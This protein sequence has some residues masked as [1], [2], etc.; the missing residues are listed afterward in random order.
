M[1]LVWNCFH[2]FFVLCARHLC[3]SHPVLQTLQTCPAPSLSLSLARP[4]PLTQVRKDL[5]KTLETLKTVVRRAPKRQV[6]VESMPLPSQKP[7]GY[8]PPT[9]SDDASPRPA[10]PASPDPAQDC[11]A[12]GAVS[13]TDTSAPVVGSQEETVAPFSSVLQESRDKHAG[14]SN[15]YSYQARTTVEELSETAEASLHTPSPT[16]AA[17]TTA[18]ASG[19]AL[20]T[21]SNSAPPQEGRASTETASAA[22]GM[23]GEAAAAA[24]AA[25]S[26]PKT[27]NSD[28]ARPAAS[29][30]APAGDDA[31]PSP[32]AAVVAAAEAG[33]GRPAVSPAAESDR[34][35]VDVKRASNKGSASGDETGS[36]SREARGETA[37]SPPLNGTAEAK[38]TAAQVRPPPPP[39][40]PS[41][42]ARSPG[43]TTQAIQLPTTGYQFELMWRS[44]DGSPQ[45][46]LELLRAVPPSSVAKFFRRTPIEVDL[47]GEVLR[48]VGGAFLP[49]KPAT[50]LRWLKSLS[51]ACR[52]GMT[53]ALLGEADGRAAAREVLKRL[54]A[55]PPAKVDPRDVDVLRRQFLV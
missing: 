26:R 52:F 32:G 31:P 29:E 19:R 48:D 44:T 16:P 47:L 6:K 10:C 38:D 24:A 30:T 7:R 54:E 42:D 34:G 9:K 50:A 33:P 18:A 55:A 36:A 22:S 1:L 20:P 17:P 4:C 2:A 15:V 13:A 35:D 43:S 14:E 51:K 23:D 45:A 28:T 21:G 46:R 3:R 27:A 53:V 49:R 39:V 37:P 40:R 41:T 8:S 5:S 11:T 25:G 12:V